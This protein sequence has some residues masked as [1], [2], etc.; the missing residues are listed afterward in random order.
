MSGIG[1]SQ[2]SGCTLM[3]VIGVLPPDKEL[4]SHKS[5]DIRLNNSNLITS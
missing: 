5:Y 4:A 2:G 1:H 3:K